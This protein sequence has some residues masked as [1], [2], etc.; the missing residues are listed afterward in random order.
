MLG[1][2]TE[3]WKQPSEGPRRSHTWED[4][5]PAGSS[6]SSV[7]ALCTRLD[8]SENTT[9]SMIA[10]VSFVGAI[11]LYTILGGLHGEDYKITLRMVR[12]D[13]QQLEDEILLHVREL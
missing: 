9:S 2:L 5:L 1:Y 6:I 7:D 8:N 3:L 11:Q 13:G 10:A 4:N 12:S